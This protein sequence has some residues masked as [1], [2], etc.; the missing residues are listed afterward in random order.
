M[1]A[2]PSTRPNDESNFRIGAV[3]R[4]TGISQHVLRVWEK[5]YG[6]VEPLRSETGSSRRQ[7]FGG[8]CV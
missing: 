3:C 1:T 5:R 7:T 4:M 8:I 6:V 2:S